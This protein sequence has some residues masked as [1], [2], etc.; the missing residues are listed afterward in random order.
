MDEILNWMKERDPEQHEFHQA[1]FGVLNTI[2]PV[3]DRHPGYRRLAVLERII[4]P[5]RVIQF[6]VP[7]MDDGGQVQ[8]N[9]GY[10]VQMSSALG[11]Y[12]GGLRFHP[13]VNLGIMKFLAFEQVFKNA[14]TPLVLGGAKGGADFD[15]RGRSDGEVMHFCQAQYAGTAR[16]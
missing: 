7:W 4:E 14:L 13:S 2:R 10:R 16:P 9:R 6:R 15:A 5:E 3:L 1:V 8:V 11:P 12:K